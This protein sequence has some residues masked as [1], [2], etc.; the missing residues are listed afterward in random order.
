M[1]YDTRSFSF[2]FS[3]YNEQNDPFDPPAQSGS[4]DVTMS[5]DDPW[6]KVMYQFC[7][8]L[9]GVYG[10]DIADQ[11]MVYN[12]HTDTTRSLTEIVFEHGGYPWPAGAEYDEDENQ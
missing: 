9:S 2:S 3:Q 10:Y 5:Q 1:S 12:K 8:F 6:T 11:I 7:L 4:R